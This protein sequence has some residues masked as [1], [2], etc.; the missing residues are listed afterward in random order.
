MSK[1]AGSEWVHLKTGKQVTVAVRGVIEETGRPCLIYSEAGNPTIWVR[2]EA[3]FLDGRFKQLSYR[4]VLDFGD[5]QIY[6]LLKTDVPLSE[7]A[8]HHPGLVRVLDLEGTELWVAN[9]S[10]N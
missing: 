10:I 3:V 6:L 4:A 7:I 8:R 5:H 1:Y 9:K 2:D